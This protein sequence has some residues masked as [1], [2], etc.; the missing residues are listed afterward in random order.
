MSESTKGYANPQ[1]DYKNWRYT[2]RARA[3]V[4]F[5]D[6]LKATYLEEIRK[7]GKRALAAL[8]AG[9]NASTV[10]KHLKEDPEFST[11]F[12]AAYD[13]YRE[14]RVKKLETQAMNGFEEVIFS[15]TGEKSTRK[16]YESN[17]RAMVLRAYA[18]EL[19]QERSA[20]DITVKS[21][22]L[23]IP[24]TQ[25]VEEWEAQFIADQQKNALPEAKE[26]VMEA[27]FTED[28]QGASVKVEP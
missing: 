1:V 26:G 4:K 2:T 28:A 21:G 6:R 12:D 19:Y 24:A 27:E 20:I 13:E 25:T 9:V 17:L 22:V 8:K 16:R 18:P 14:A 10:S 5:D 7:S 3:E 11:A 23:L 15:P